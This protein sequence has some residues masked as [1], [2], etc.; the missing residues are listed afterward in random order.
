MNDKLEIW[1][2]MIDS[3]LA[4]AKY[5]SKIAFRAGQKLGVVDRLPY[6]LDK[7]GR[8]AL[9]KAQVLCVMK[10]PSLS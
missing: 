9:Y 5:I 8:A 4:W 1:G 2:V 10:Y 6:K 7:R 3:K